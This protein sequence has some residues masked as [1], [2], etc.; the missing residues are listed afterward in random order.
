M[1]YVL[2]IVGI[3]N[4]ILQRVIPAKEFTII[5]RY[6]NCVSDRVY[7][8]GRRRHKSILYGTVNHSIQYYRC[9]KVLAGQFS[10]KGGG[11]VM[12]MY[13]ALVYVNGRE[14]VSE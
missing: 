2:Y 7:L 9:S 1:D 4:H 13:T 5:D 12:K 3:R 14:I 11:A 8:S 10:I 6:R